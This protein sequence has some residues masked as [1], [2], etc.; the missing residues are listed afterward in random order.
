MDV[1]TPKYVS[2]NLSD[3]LEYLFNVL[4]SQATLTLSQIGL[5]GKQTTNLEGML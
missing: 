2:F 1:C 3:L 4:E 5:E